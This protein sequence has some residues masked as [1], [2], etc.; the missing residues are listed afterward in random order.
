MSAAHGRP[1]PRSVPRGGMAL[2]SARVRTV[3][4][5]HGRPKPSSLRCGD[6]ARGAGGF[7]Q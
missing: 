1:K 7:R 5:A 6:E 3:L 2:V 4:A